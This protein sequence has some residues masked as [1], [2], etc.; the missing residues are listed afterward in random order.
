[1]AATTIGMFELMSRL[2]M[3][4]VDHWGE[5]EDLFGGC[6]ETPADIIFMPGTSKIRVKLAM[7]IL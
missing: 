6:K 2:F 4:A 1:M 5:G 7:K 3:L